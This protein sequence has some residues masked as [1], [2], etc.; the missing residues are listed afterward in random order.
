MRV[1]YSGLSVPIFG[2]FNYIIVGG[3]SLAIL[4]SIDVVA[5]FVERE[6]WK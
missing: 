1:D 4:F 3:F 2:T 5:W 6:R